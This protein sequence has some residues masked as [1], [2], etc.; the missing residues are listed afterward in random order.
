MAG[1]KFQIRKAQKE[2]AAAIVE[3]VKELSVYERLSHKMRATVESFEKYGFGQ[4][5]FFHTLLADAIEKGKRQTLGFALYFF[6]FSTF[7]GKPTLYLE[8][9]F[10]KPEYRGKGIGK[11]LLIELAGIALEKDCARMEWAVLDW[12]EPSIKFYESLGAKPMSGWTVFRMERAAI[13]SLAES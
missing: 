1:F 12:N 13:K 10:V 4:N 7:E 6:T 11:R 2:D 5:P 9:L 3:L 8:D